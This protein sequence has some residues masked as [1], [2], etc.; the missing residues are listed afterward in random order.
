MIWVSCD[1]IPCDVRILAEPSVVPGFVWVGFHNVPGDVGIPTEEVISPSL[2]GVL[3][4]VVEPRYKV[5]VCH[6]NFQ[7]WV[8]DTP[9]GRYKKRLRTDL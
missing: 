9:A 7:W 1:D 3:F 8:V 2:V 6:Q 5:K 4:D